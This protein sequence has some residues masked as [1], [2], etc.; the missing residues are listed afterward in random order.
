MASAEEKA[1]EIIQSWQNQTR[2]SLSD[3]VIKNAREHRF[4]AEDIEETIQKLSEF[5]TEIHITLAQSQTVQEMDSGLNEVFNDL[6]VNK[7]RTLESYGILPDKDKAKVSKLLIIIDI[8]LAIIKP[9]LVELDKL[10]PQKVKHHKP[11]FFETMFS[12]K[13]EPLT[14]LLPSYELPGD[15][16]GNSELGGSKRK[17]K[18]RKIKKS[19]K[20]R[21]SR[22]LR[23]LKKCALK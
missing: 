5:I 9:L 3:M 6:I 8:M 2:V 15:E 1:L 4:T 7:W 16:I 12:K 18:Q 22:K 20:S 11:S 21:K 19:R 17:T 14:V 23:T 10:L 13:S